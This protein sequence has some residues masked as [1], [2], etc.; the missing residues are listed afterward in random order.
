MFQQFITLSQQSTGI[1]PLLSL[2]LL[3]VIVVSIERGIYF[4]RLVPS[5]LKLNQELQ[6]TNH[7]EINALR[8]ISRQYEGTVFEAPLEAA[9]EAR[10]LDADHMDRYIDEA[11]VHELPRLDRFLWMIDACVTLGP[12]IGLLGTIIGITESFNVFGTGKQDIGAVMGGI[13]HALA[14]TACGL[15]VAIVGVTANAYFGKRLRVAMLQLDL[16][17]FTCVK[18]FHLKDHVRLRAQSAAA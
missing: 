5:G 10:H 6:A 14:A 15:L 17:K 8:T 9:L 16:L 12:L 3:L 2:L 11:I 18:H 7:H 1:I 13:G 4:A